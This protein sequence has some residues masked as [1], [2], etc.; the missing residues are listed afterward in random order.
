M[1]VKYTYPSTSARVFVSPRLTKSIDKDLLI[2]YYMYNS[3][4]IARMPAVTVRQTMTQTTTLLE[5][6]A[7]TATVAL[8]WIWGT[9]GVRAR[10]R[11]KWLY[12][13]GGSN[14]PE[15]A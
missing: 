2:I 12:C 5:D 13:I 7:A 1:W 14:N 6:V 9:V 15:I 8:A 3:G 10:A 11:N 4:W